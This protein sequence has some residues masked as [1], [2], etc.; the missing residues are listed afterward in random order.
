M[1]GGGAG[2]GGEVGEVGVEGS[3]SYSTQF[4]TGILRPADQ[5]LTFFLS[6]SIA[7]RSK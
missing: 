4:N 6:F 5:T 1:E 7:S 2:G 3:E